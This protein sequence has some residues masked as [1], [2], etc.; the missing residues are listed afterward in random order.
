MRTCLEHARAAGRILEAELLLADILKCSRERVFA[1]P[2]RALE[3]FEAAVFEEKWGRLMAG[4]SLAYLVGW[5]EFFGLHFHVDRRVLVPRPET[6]H[7][8]EEAL[9]LLAEEPNPRILDV[10][11]GCGAIALSVQ[12]RRPEAQVFASDVS[13]DALV[14][15][16]ANAEHLGL[17]RVQFFQSDLLADLPWESWKLQGIVANLPYIGEQEFHFV[18]RSVEAFE[19]RVALFGGVDGL[20]LYRRLFDQ[21]NCSIKPPSWVIGE[22]GSL[23]RERLEGLI[24]QGFSEADVFFHTDVAGL[25]RYFIIEFPH[26]K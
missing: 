10:G 21:I 22:F 11:T 26:A 20:D 18:E 1:Y 5:K 13:G 12:A 3:D 16:R 9:R 14:V 8:V 2:E 25:D 15:A 4:E 6:E 7:L 24:R 23:Q 19:P 17:R